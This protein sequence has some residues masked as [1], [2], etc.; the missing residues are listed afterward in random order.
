MRD[1]TVRM[2]SKRHSGN[3][4]QVKFSDF[5]DSD[6]YKTRNHFLVIPKGKLIGISKFL[7]FTVGTL[8]CDGGPRWMSS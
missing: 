1:V 2:Q 5:L 8:K 4:I 3:A 6:L 7:F